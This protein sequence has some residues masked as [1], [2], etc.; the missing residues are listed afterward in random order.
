MPTSARRL[1]EYVKYG[2]AYFEIAGEKLKLNLYQNTVP[3]E[4]PEYVDYLFLPFT[5]FTCGNGSYGGEI[6]LD[7][8]I[9]KGAGMVLN[10]NKAYNPSCVYSPKY[11]CPIPTPV[12]YLSIR[13]EAGVKDFGKH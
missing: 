7:A 9:P 11:S 8:Y 2:E 13:M 3:S 10:F 1:P 12:N 4:D 5:D 6:F